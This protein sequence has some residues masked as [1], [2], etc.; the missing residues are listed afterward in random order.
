MLNLIAGEFAKLKRKKIVPFIVLLSML[1]P[2]IVVYTSKMGMGNDTSVEFLKGRFDLSYTMMLGYGLVFLGPCL[3]GILASILFFMERDNDT[4]KNLCV[5]PVTTSRLIVAKLSVVLVYGLFY[6]FCNFAFMTFFTWILNAGIIYDIGF[7]LIFSF[8]FG[9]GITIATLPVIVLIIYFNKSYLISTL[10][11]FFYAILNWSVLSIVETNLSLI[12]IINLFPTLCLMNWS[13]K[14]MLGRM[15][16]R[17]L[18][19]E[20]YLLFP[21][22][23][24]AFVVMV[25]TLILSILLILHFY[26]K[27]AR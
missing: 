17:Y 18:L 23:I 8:I 6:T 3:L 13:S 14:K 11:S 16:D 5:I 20:A 2:L 21:S 12:K 25:I 1:F 22:D 26:K 9:I 4:F 10:L 7:K 27:W 19:P 24:W 15:T